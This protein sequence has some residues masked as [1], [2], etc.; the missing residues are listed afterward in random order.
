M[1]LRAYLVSAVVLSAFSVPVL[2]SSIE[3]LHWWT[4]GGEARAADVLRHYW[5][6]E[7]NTWV[8]SAISG[9][10]GQSAMAVLKS[11]ALAGTPPHAAHLKGSELQE[12]AELGFLRNLDSIA[13][14]D[15]WNTKLPD[16]VR[17][18]LSY[19]GHYVAVPI[20]IHRV[21]WLWANPQVFARLKLSPPTSWPEFL[22][23]ADRLK[24]EGIVPLAIGNDS[25]QLMILFES[26]V[27]GEAGSDFY[28][29]AFVQANPAVLRSAEMIRVLTLFHQLRDD[30][31][32]D[33][34]SVNWNEATHMLM[35]GT[36][37]MQIMG[38]WAKSELP[39][40]QHGEI[41][42]ICL[43]APGTRGKFAYNVDS[44]AMFDVQDSEKQQAQT[45]LVRMIM[46]P[47]F[48]QTFNR[49]KGSI[50]VYLNDPLHNFDQCAQDSSQELQR[51]MK[52]NNLVPSMAESMANTNDVKTALAD[53]LTSYFNDPNG[54]A[55][56]AAEQLARAVLS[57]ER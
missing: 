13:N 8:D 7:G 38:D 35:S 5:Q 28:R 55:N 45:Q 14:D 56:Q 30:V 1:T 19:Q 21:N 52:T 31:P 17:Q 26:I 18:R 4:A 36:A 41:Q 51:A 24:H 37:A 40:V 3:V 9:G 54:N 23:T 34:A 6:Q 53:V 42:P 46:Q 33:F 57:A 10:G 16:F 47:Q 22:D 15:Q 39:V 27:L 49:V 29:Q 20:G 2:A 11:R 32:D 25:W 48:Q 50:P 12:W 44:I 43:P